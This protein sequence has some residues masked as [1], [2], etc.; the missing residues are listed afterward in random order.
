MN[1]RNFDLNLVRVLATLMEERSV[2]KAATRLGLTQPAVSAALTR[3][4]DA[5]GDPLFVRTR[6]GMAPT[7]RGEE[8][9]QLAIAALR[10]F[11]ELLEA[12][13]FDPNTADVTLTVGANDY[14][15]FSIVAPL[16][17][18]LRKSTPG[19]RLEI[20]PLEDDI[21][22][23]L[24][25]QEID[26]AITLL[27][28]PPR[29]AIVAPLLTDD[30][31]GAVDKSNDVVGS[32]ISLDHFC[33]LDHVRV[34]AANNAR[35]IDPVDDQLMIR[36]RRRNVIL[37]VPNFFMIPRLLRG[38]DLFSVVPVRLIQYFDWTLKPVA[39]PLSLPGFTMNLIWHERTDGS[40]R[41]MWLREQLTSIADAIGRTGASNPKQ[42]SARPE[43][44]RAVNTSK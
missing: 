21:G 22:G 7:V 42:P 43:V 44:R 14:G 6:R 35:L 32:R 31:V 20:R 23:Q 17:H 4:R 1:V 5:F 18:R 28:Q 8:L 38:S 12:K 9:A 11:E 36:G 40:L 24:E 16:L 25:R 2:T 19:L 30:F 13:S 3:L 34:S 39:L 37:S 29:N 33:S 41:H 27:S 15:Q 10:D 26:V